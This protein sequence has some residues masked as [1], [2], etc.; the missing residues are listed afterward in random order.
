MPDITMCRDTKCPQKDYCFRYTAQPS[1]YRQAYFTESPK[2]MDG[3]P[4][5][6]RDERKLKP[7]QTQL[8]MTDKEF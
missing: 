5:F 4:Y 7:P 8:N 3:C 1:E 6:M 2:K